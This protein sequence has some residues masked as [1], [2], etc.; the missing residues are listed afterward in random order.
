MDYEAADLRGYRTRGT[1]VIGYAREYE[2]A[3]LRG[4]RKKGRW[5]IGYQAPGTRGRRGIWEGVKRGM[6]ERMADVRNRD[7][8]LLTEVR[9]IMQDVR[10]S[11]EQRRWL[12]DRL[13]NIT[14]RITG[15]PGGHGDAKGYEE[16][17]ADI[18]E[19]EEKYQGEVSGWMKEL[20]AA[21]DIVNGIPDL[22]M[23]VFVKMRYLLG[24]GR[25]R[26]ME[27]LGLKRWQYDRIVRVIEQARGMGEVRW[28]ECGI[29]GKMLRND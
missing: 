27:E 16:N 12:Q 10:C 9:Y 6:E 1:M 22:R 28:E 5:V 23:R 13:F 20:R 19:M 8:P 3:D 18:S 17:F 11:E 26:I 4:Y 2:E 14:M 29:E 21:Q 24:D 15:M 7:I 25:K